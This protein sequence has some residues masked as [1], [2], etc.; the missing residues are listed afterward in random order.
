MNLLSRRD[1]VEQTLEMVDDR[2][3][4]TSAITLFYYYKAVGLTC[5]DLVLHD[6][7]II[8]QG[9]FFGANMLSNVRKRR[10]VLKLI[11]LLIVFLGFH[12]ITWHLVYAI[13]P[14]VPALLR[15]RSVILLI[16]HLEDDSMFFTPTV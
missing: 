14:S 6:S 3:I 7:N 1:A 11:R 10:T 12:R 15:D 16:A 9:I 8:L 13:S 5:T 4:C 2:N